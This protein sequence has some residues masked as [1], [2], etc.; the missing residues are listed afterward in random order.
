[1]PR[2]IAIPAALV[3][4]ASLACSATGCHEPTSPGN[5]ALASTITASEILAWVGR[6]ADDS[7]RGRDTPSPGIES[8][9]ATLAAEFTRLG[10][11]PAFADQRYV[12]HYPAPPSP[13]ATD[14]APNV[15]AILAGSDPVL[16]S[17]YV[18]LIAHLDHL[19]IGTD[20]IYNGADDNASGTAGVLELAE[21]FAATRPRPRRSVLFLLVTGEEYGYWGS[22]WYVDHPSVPLGSIVGVLTL[23]MI[24]R[25]GADSIQV[26][27]LGLSTMA[28][29]VTEA[30]DAHPD[31]GF[32]TV[33]AG[34]QS[35]S[36]FVPFSAKGIPW[37]FLFAGHHP[38]YH[39][40][41]DETDRI[42]PDKAARVARLAFY[43]VFTVANASARP[44]WLSGPAPPASA[45]LPAP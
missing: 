13:G 19:G 8:A 34:P 5:V 21:A 17:E 43:T 30:L 35:G 26:G 1:M 15:G 25:N 28:L 39:T 20:S 38:D 44:Q 45:R 2:R 6:L 3:L 7:L 40:P 29:S 22:Q 23:D 16:A 36:D 42:D 27:G 37:V 12:A 4:A 41:K 9:A 32:Q 31:L 14:S 33:L 18:V 10:L 11:A 24:S